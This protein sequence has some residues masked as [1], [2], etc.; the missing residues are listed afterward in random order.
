MG[1]VPVWGFQMLIALA[2]SFVF[3]LNKVL[4]LLASNI[5]FGP[6]VP[7]IIYAIHR[8][9]A[10][11]MGK[12]ARPLIFSTD[13]TFDQ[14]KTDLIQYLAGAFTLAIAG[15]LIFGVITYGYLRISRQIKQ[16][17][18]LPPGP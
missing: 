4:V 11:W 17:R 5:S 14:V 7:L 9:G 10:F 13:I 6:M 15:G 3:R 8:A 1:I 2:L 18:S 16:S 12:N